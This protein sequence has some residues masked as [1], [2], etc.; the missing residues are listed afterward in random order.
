MIF[1]F[2][3]KCGAKI[4][5]IFYM[6]KRARFFLFFFIYICVCQKKIVTLQRKV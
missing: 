2:S 4:Q 3:T 5:K 1:M 6:C